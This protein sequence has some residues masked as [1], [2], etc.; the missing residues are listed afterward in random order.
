[1]CW[2]HRYNPVIITTH[3][4]TLC[5]YVRDRILT[6]VYPLS[7]AH[8]LIWRVLR[9]QVDIWFWH[10]QVKCPVLHHALKP[11]GGWRWSLGSLHTG[12]AWRWVVRWKLWPL[13]PQEKK[14]VFERRLGG[15]RIKSGRGGGENSTRISNLGR[16]ACR[17]SPYSLR[18][19]C[20]FRILVACRSSS[21]SEGVQSEIYSYVLQFLFRMWPEMVNVGIELLIKLKRYWGCISELQ[22]LAVY[23]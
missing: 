12:T 8:I 11:S 2:W 7:I 3:A 10:T 21:L 23:N 4:P 22:I 19:C 17:L 18:Y 15:L 13:Y 9:Q 14:P 6:C 1:M 20:S 5:A 16:P